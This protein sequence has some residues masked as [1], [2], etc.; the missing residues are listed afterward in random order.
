[1]KTNPPSIVPIK[2]YLNYY[3]LEKYL[4]EGC[5]NFQNNECLSAEEFFLIV[6]WKNPKHGRRYLSYL[7]D[8]DIG[9]LTG[10][11]YLAGKISDNASRKN[12]LEILLNDG[13]KN[14]RGIRLATASAI[15]TILYP[16]EFTVYDVR[17]R[18]QLRKHGLWQEEPDE[19][20]PF[21]DIT[22]DKDVV[23]KYLEKYL[24]A[25]NSLREEGM[26]LRDCDRALWA[27]DWLEDL[28]EW[29]KN[30][31]KSKS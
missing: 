18:K 3:W 5:S 25:V 22:Y 11:I 24:P 19:K 1:M 6:E 13:K 10:N 28:R 4:D 23:N 12:R 27:N 16:T 26:S 9:T 21:G 14:R 20:P 2:D 8:K 31:H 7:T 29:M 17:V 30:R 15:L